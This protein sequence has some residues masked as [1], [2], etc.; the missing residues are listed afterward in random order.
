MVTKISKSM[1]RSVFDSKMFEKL[2]HLHFVD[3]MGFVN[4]YVKDEEVAKDIVH[5][6]F[7]VLWNN[8][9]R[10]DFSYSMKSY[11]FT[12]SRNY[13]LNY[14]KHLRVVASNEREMTAFIESTNDELEQREKRLF[15]LHEKLLLLPQKQQEILK[16]CFIE[17][18]GYKDV[19]EEFG[20]SLNTVKTHLSRALKFLREEMHDEVVLLFFQYRKM[21][22]GRF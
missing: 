6:V 21:G 12:L 4:S 8:R 3:L 13:A 1:V 10:L 2:F 18:K 19:A 16:K 17:G 9:K 7:L 14:L 20:I 11:L 22:M 5:D 15:R